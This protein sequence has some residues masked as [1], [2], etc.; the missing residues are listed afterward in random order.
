MSLL[1]R[2]FG[3]RADRE[4]LRPLYEALVALARDPAWYRQG[5]TPDTLQGRFEIL[6]SIVALAL[7]R[8]E[9]EPSRADS[10]RL[11]ELFIDD[12]DG[13]VRQ[14]GIGDILVGKHVGRMTGALGGRLGAFRSALEKESGLEEP[15]RRNVFAGT[16]PSETAVRFV[17]ERLRA[18]HRG[19]A[20]T[21]LEPF[22]RGALPPS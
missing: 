9:A 13:T 10:V 5:E 19:F 4:A 20:A 2:L 21:G 17:A 22:L 14:L 11:A 16:P 3:A 12:M 6:A 8:L 1:S 15:V 7:I 18:L